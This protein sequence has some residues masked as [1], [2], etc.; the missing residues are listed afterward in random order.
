[1][2]LRAAG[3]SNQSKVDYSPGVSHTWYDVAFGELQ[4]GCQRLVKS[5]YVE[6]LATEQGRQ[7]CP[8]WNLPIHS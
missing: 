3:A 6:Y 2:V 5:L 8:H 4:D 7:S 1:M